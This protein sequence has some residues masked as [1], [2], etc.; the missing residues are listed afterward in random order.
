MSRWLFDLGNTRLKF[1]PLRED[2]TLGEVTALVHADGELA[3]A[4]DRV[5]PV[6]QASAYLASVASDPLTVAALDVLT[7]RFRL[8]SRARSTRQ[9]AGVRSAYA[10]P[11]RLGV[12]R[13]LALAGARARGPGAWLVVGIGT[14][15]TV[16]LMDRD[17]L[18]RGGCIAPSPQ[19]MRS[20][21]H[22]AAAQLPAAGGT[23][24]DFASDT[25]DALASGC[26][27]ATLGLIERSLRIGHQLLDD[28]PA[29]LLHG[30]GALALAGHLP[31]ATH[32]P[33]LV[34][35]GLGRWSRIGATSARPNL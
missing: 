27:G 31:R 7:M 34:L 29:L 13:L 32:A 24:G 14:A 23:Y 6:G 33:S 9:C 35:E 8:V 20:A 10:E 17:G 21:L 5:L 12:D 22:A 1:A 19:L 25:A 15:T 26:D 28:A 3:R 18:H 4:L 16:D 11:S 30:G 2:G